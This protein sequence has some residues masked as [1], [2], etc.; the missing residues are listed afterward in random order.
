MV[1]WDYPVGLV[2][3]WFWM[4]IPDQFPHVILDEYIVMPNHM[5]GIV[6]IINDL[7]NI[8]GEN[9]RSAINRGSAIDNKTNNIHTPGGIT[10][11][12]NPMLSDGNLG[13]IIRWYKGRCSYEIHQRN[14]HDF[15]WQGR[16]WD[17]IIRD[18]QS[19]QRIRNYIHDN[20]LNW[21][22]NKFYGSK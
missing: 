9:R 20:P 13:Q 18:E 17:H 19:L 11:N 4:Q 14:Y 5:H 10:G 3:N 8:V 12:H 2:A 21:K 6:C 1:L 16:F 22:A 15:Q 7:K